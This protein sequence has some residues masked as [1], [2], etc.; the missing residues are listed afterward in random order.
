MS[1]LFPKVTKILHFCNAYEHFGFLI[2][3]GNIYRARTTNNP[4]NNKK[5]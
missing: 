3:E 2:M 4:P 1:Q 5:E